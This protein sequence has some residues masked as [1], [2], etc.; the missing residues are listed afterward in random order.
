[1]RKITQYILTL[2]VILS[3]A[4]W[5]LQTVTAQDEGLQIRITQV[6]NSKF[7]QV[8]VYISVTNAA[9]EPMAIDPSHLQI[10]ENGQLMA[11][12]AVSGSGD[13]GSLT[14]LLVVDVSGSMEKSGKLAGAKTAAKTYVDQM[15]PSDQAGLISF[16]TA[17]QNVQPV[18]SDHQ[19]LIRAIDSLQPLGNTAMF[20]AL[21]RAIQSLEGVPGRKAII[22]MTDGLDNRSRATADE[23]IT[24]IGPGGLSISTI[25][26]GDPK[27]AGNNYGLD[28]PALRSLAERAGGAYSFATDPAA[29]AGLYQLYGRAL[30]GEYRITY[31]SPSALRDGINRT[32]AVSLA[33]STL[34]AQGKYN[35]G[36]VL[37]EVARR[38]WV[39]FGGI[40]A[41][42]AVLLVIPMLL[43]R[44][45]EALGGAKRKSRIKLG[46]PASHRKVRIKLK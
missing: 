31:T 32:L 19:A 8:T 2:I 35:P 4:A 7:P 40:L 34:S 18:T 28:E 14:T 21:V 11:P 33:G 30:Q 16:N 38:S 20:D 5:P 6:D 3:A 22:V 1:M 15:R 10:Y 41:G 25:G 45:G 24:A 29:L 27:E 9:G 44:G 17:V 13:I 26:L 12:Q 37:P 43:S 39:L 36:G 46:K 23:V 42:L